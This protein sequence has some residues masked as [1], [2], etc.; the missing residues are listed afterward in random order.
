MSLLFAV[1]VVLSA[2][3]KVSLAGVLGTSGFLRFD[4]IH[5]D[6]TVGNN[7]LTTFSLNNAGS[8]IIVPP[9]QDAVLGSTEFALTYGAQI[10]MEF[11]LTS[12]FP[13]GSITPDSFLVYLLDAAHNSV[14][15]TSGGGAGPLFKFDVVGTV[16]G[17]LTVYGNTTIGANSDI[18]WGF[19]SIA[20]FEPGSSTLFGS[21][22]TGAARTNGGGAVPEPASLT[23]WAFGALAIGYGWRRR[24]SK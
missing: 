24:L 12:A 6:A 14:V 11:I 18:S 13:S 15:S 19:Q 21:V 8:P 1:A 17:Q 4:F 16:P 20:S 23:M 22:T 5:N 9:A 7:Q 2:V 10:D 3:P